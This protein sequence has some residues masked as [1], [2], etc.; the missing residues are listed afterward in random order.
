MLI[1]KKL[2]IGVYPSDLDHLAA[3]VQPLKE[4]LRDHLVLALVALG[5]IALAAL[6]RLLLVL[7]LAD[8]VVP[9]NVL[10][11][12]AHGANEEHG[13]LVLP[14]RRSITTRIKG[15]QLLLTLGGIRLALLL[16]SRSVQGFG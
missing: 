4:I 12:V 9:E 5:L 6:I 13:G 10:L 7:V 11:N 15:H 14:R 16:R 8:L 2:L 1:V 3:G